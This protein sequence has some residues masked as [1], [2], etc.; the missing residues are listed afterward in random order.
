MPTKN[1]FD[2]EE[3]KKNWIN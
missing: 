1:I 2:D 3:L